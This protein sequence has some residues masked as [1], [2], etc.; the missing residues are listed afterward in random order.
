MFHR[1]LNGLTA[2]IRALGLLAR[3]P[4]LWRYIAVPIL[5][6]LLVG[7]TLYAALLLAGFRA[8]D[9]A[10]AG[11][12]AWAAV[13]ATVLRALLVLL[14]LIATGFVLVRFGV[15]LGS[16]WYARLSDQLER[17]R[18]GGLPDPATGL[19]AGLRDL[20]RALGFELKKLLLVL[21]V[22]LGLLLLN[23]LPVAGQ[24]LAT[25]GSIAL[26]ADGRLPR[27]PRLPAGAPAAE[28][29]RQAGGHPQASAGHRRLRLGG[30][31]AGQHPVAEPAGDP[32]LRRGRHVAVLRRDG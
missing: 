4:R 12:P 25:A 29:P 30:T 21:V 23:A 18:L 16:P 8:I 2:P 22:A 19:A 10:L 15:V 27:L 17:L 5:V 20:A 13:F 31:G 6:N 14:L 24:L 9:G 32:G 28:L 3:A 7:A 11:L 26:G 1:F